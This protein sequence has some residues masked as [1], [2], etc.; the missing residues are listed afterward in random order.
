ML[1]GSL[2]GQAQ[3][4]Q[5]LEG[6]LVR[7]TGVLLPLPQRFYAAPHHNPAIHSQQDA[8]GGRGAGSS[9]H[10]QPPHQLAP[11]P[12][13]GGP[14]AFG[15]AYGSGQQWGGAEEG[16]QGHDGGHEEWPAS[17]SGTSAGK[18]AV[19]W[20]AAAGSALPLLQRRPPPGQQQQQRQ[21]QQQSQQLGG[22]QHLQRGLP[23]DGRAAPLGGLQPF[24]SA[25]SVGP[26]TV[27]PTRGGRAGNGR[28]AGPSAG[29]SGSYGRGP[30]QGQGWA[31]GR[32]AGGRSGGGPLSLPSLPGAGFSAG[33]RDALGT[34]WGG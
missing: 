16:R 28:A 23:Q 13:P 32:A 30:G 7:L 3:H 8:A 9:S 12:W 25:A 14:G 15:P 24:A 33:S 5:H 2:L 22:Q 10:R 21:R 29:G 19:E 6:L 26:A 20:P 34:G 18:P 4:I 11:M 17:S 31:G 27:S 1:R